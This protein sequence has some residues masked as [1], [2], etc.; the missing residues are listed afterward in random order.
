MGRVS[1]QC[2]GVGLV[3]AIGNTGN[4][5]LVMRMRA[6]QLLSISDRLPCRSR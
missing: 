6:I 4:S 3:V 2:T 1:S 5:T